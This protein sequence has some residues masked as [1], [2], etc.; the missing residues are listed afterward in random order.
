MLESNGTFTRCML[1]SLQCVDEKGCTLVPR[2]NPSAMAIFNLGHKPNCISIVLDVRCAHARRLTKHPT[3]QLQ[4]HTAFQ[5]V[6]DPSVR[7]AASSGG[8]VPLCHHPL[9]NPGRA[10]HCVHTGQRAFTLPA[11]APQMRTPVVWPGF[12]PINNAAN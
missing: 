8:T 11:T 3:N 1:V 6:D 10:R 7:K 12:S 9:F 5:P 4:T 2:R